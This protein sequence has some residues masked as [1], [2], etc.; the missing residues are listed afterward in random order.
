MVKTIPLESLDSELW[1]KA[2]EKVCVFSYVW[3]V[4][5]II[6]D[7]SKSRFDKSLSDC[8]SVD[9]L[10]SPCHNFTLN[11][12]DRPDGEWVSWNMLMP[13]FEFP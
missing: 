1:K 8:F 5:A 13:E 4:G 9:S 11:F 6:T 10:K 3:S 12:K 2:L 7:E